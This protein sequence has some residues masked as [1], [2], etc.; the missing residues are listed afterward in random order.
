MSDIEDELDICNNSWVDRMLD[1]DGDRERGG[2]TGDVSVSAGAVF[3][4]S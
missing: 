1:I 2:G 3:K 4:R